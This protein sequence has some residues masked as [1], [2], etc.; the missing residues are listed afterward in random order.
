MLPGKSEMSGV[1]SMPNIIAPKEYS[2]EFCAS[3]ITSMQ[4]S[5]KAAIE[6]LSLTS[7]GQKELTKQAIKHIEDSFVEIKESVKS[8]E[9]NSA[10]DTEKTKPIYSEIKKLERALNRFKISFYAGGIT[11]LVFLL[12]YA[13]TIFQMLQSA[14]KNI[15]V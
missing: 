5:L 1:L 12:G 3:V 15:G 7:S 8:L 6:A 10:F 4:S 13:F 11:A 9:A 2:P 14:I